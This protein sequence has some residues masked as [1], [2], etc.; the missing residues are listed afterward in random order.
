MKKILALLMVTIIVSGQV[1]ATEA[2]A[3]NPIPKQKQEAIRAQR[4]AAFEKRL[5]LTEEQ[6]IKA[7]EL[8]VKGYEKIKPV[9]DEIIAK[10]QEAKMVKMSRI[11]VQAQEEKLAKIDAELKVLEKKAHDIRKAN[12]K[13]FESILTRKQKKILKD[14]KKEGRKKYQANHP[15]KKIS[16]PQAKLGK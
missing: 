3:K 8:R 1:F 13:D 6:K 9:I 16:F 7:K 10:K 12:M 14:M 4:E 11:A 5:G 15:V 2:V